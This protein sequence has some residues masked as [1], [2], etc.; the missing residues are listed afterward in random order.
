MS[1][2]GTAGKLA[3]V[4]E[5]RNLVVPGKIEYAEKMRGLQEDFGPERRG[6]F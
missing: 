5:C 3:L 2:A 6:M 1:P 4:G